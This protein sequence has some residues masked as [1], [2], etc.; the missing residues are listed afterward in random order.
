MRAPFFN[1]CQENVTNT[2]ERTAPLAQSLFDV[3]AVVKSIV[4][5]NEVHNAWHTAQSHRWK[6]IQYL[7]WPVKMQAKRFLW[8]EVIG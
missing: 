3:E 7:D 5:V 6:H 1:T 2:I 4:M 8:R